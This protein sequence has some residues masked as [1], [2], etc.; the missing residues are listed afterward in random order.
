MLFAAIA[1]V[2]GSFAPS[3]AVCAAAQSN[4]QAEGIKA[5]ENQKYAEAAALFEKALGADPSDYGARFHLALAYSLSG[6]ES[7][8]VAQYQK[9]LEQKP[10]LY[11]AELNLGFLLVQLRRSS[12]AVPLLERAAAQRPKEFRPWYGLGEARLETGDVAGAQK[13]LEAALAIDPKSAAAEAALGRALARQQKLAEAAPH[14]RKAAALD[15][16][17]RDTLLE[18]A[19]FYEA[20]R[21]LAEAIAL[22]REFPELPAARERLGHLLAESGQ[23]AEAIAQLESAVAGSPSVANRLALAQAY[24]AAK[25][26][27]K[28]IPLLEQVIAAEPQDAALRLAYG[29]LLRDQKNYQGAAAQFL[30]S[31]ELKADSIE[32]WSELASAF[33]LLEDYPRALAALDRVKALG[34]ETGS[35]AFFRAIAHDKLQQYPQALENYQKFLASSDGRFPNEEFKARQRV[36]LIQKELKR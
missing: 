34:G 13:A 25:Q 31:L 17:Y 15:A 20:A 3:M 24:V 1:L 6:R 10:G 23:A 29:R 33:L 18:L 11:E 7:E 28:A 16:G 9:V 4:S 5:L 35:H 27:A 36:R 8:A 32:A 14:Y 22:Y 21:Q 12:E 30:K 26:P 2:A 19:S